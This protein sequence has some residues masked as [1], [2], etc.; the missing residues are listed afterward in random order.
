MVLKFPN[1]TTLAPKSDWDCPERA[2][3]VSGMSSGRPTWFRIFSM[4]F[5]S[6]MAAMI[7]TFLEPQAWQLSTSMP[8]TLRRSL[9]QDFDFSFGAFLSLSLFVP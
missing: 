2:A 7:F 9:A 4:T 3:D 1:F 8:N 5:F 6:M